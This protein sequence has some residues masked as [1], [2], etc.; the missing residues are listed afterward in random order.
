[1]SPAPAPAKT[2]EQI[3]A[4]FGEVFKAI[5][6]PLQ[7]R[8]SIADVLKPY[9]AEVRKLRKAGYTWIQIRDGM[10]DP[11]IGVKVSPNTLQV[12][13]ATRQEK[14]AAEAKRQK[15]RDRLAKTATPPAAPTA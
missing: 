6:P 12:L 10:A 13:F 9:G 3:S 5:V 15:A 11:R 1:M 4:A 7:R 8:P 2:P 14:A